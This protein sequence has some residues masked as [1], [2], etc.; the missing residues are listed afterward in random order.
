MVRNEVD[1]EELETVR[2]RTMAR[3]QSDRMTVTGITAA[4]QGPAQS[5]QR[6][7]DLTGEVDLAMKAGAD[8]VVFR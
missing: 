2:R 4:V 3:R 5:T 1:E 8:A 6:A 7:L